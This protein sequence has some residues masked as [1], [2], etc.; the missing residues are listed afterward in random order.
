M[1]SDQQPASDDGDVRNRHGGNADE[2]E[3]GDV[4]NWRWEKDAETPMKRRPKGESRQ[5]QGDDGK[6]VKDWCGRRV[7]RTGI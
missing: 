1:R 3:G 7:R 6:S 4:E 2:R 5:S